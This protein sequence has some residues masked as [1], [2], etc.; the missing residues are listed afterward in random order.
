[1]IKTKVRD[2]AMADYQRIEYRISKDGQ[3]TEVVLNGTGKHCIETTTPI[4]QALG[5][6]T[7]QEFLPEYYEAETYLISDDRTPLTQTIGQLGE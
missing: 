6:I 1:M 4:E 2:L 3:I 7:H 5:T